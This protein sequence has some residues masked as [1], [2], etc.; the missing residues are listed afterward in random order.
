MSG[1]LSF[2]FDRRR[3]LATKASTINKAFIVRF[4]ADGN[5]RVEGPFVPAQVQRLI[6]T[7]ECHEWLRDWALFAIW[8]KHPVIDKGELIE[9]SPEIKEIASRITHKRYQ[10]LLAN[11][12][13][14]Q[15]HRHWRE[16]N[17]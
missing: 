14:A 11:H 2:V 13:R 15:H 12:Y 17:T 5:F 7:G 8:G 16:E 3:N 6:D 4:F 9:L 1:L 10:P